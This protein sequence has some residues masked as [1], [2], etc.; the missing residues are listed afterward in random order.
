MYIVKSFT[1]L[2]LDTKYFLGFEV[3]SVRKVVRWA[4]MKN[5]DYRVIATSEAR[6]LQEM[7][8]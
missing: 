7:V 4:K 5:H 8:P 1:F 3:L 2:S 6:N